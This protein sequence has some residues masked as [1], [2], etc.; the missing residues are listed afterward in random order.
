M[1]VITIIQSF[2]FKEPFIGALKKDKSNKNI[3][4][5]Q[6]RSSILVMKNNSRIGFLIIVTQMLLSFLYL[7]FLLSSESSEK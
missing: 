3:F 6:L 2:S 4:I 1:S 5:E 7:Y